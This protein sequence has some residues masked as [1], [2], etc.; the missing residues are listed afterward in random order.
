[1]KDLGALY[2]ENVEKGELSSSSIVP[3]CRQFPNL[4]EINDYQKIY[5]EWRLLRNTKEIESFSEKTEE[6]W[7]SVSSIKRCDG[8]RMFENICSFVFKVLSL[9]HSSAKCKN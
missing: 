7:T 4:S 3:I 2:P 1:M 9:P 8:S 5:T 6:I